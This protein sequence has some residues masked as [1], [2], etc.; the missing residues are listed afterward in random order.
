MEDPHR[1]RY[2]ANQTRYGNRHGAP[3]SG[4]CPMCGEDGPNEAEQNM[5]DRCY[6]SEGGIMPNIDEP[7]VLERWEGFDESVTIVQEGNHV[8]VL[9]NDE[10]EVR[11]PATRAGYAGAVVYLESLQQD[12]RHDARPLDW[13]RNPYA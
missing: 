12:I 4:W 2:I 1:Q 7:T 8:L 11:I 10:V 6:V 13:T 5:C 9:R 3:A